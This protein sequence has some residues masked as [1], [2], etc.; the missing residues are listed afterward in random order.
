VAT[1]GCIWNR[2]LSNE[3]VRTLGFSFYRARH[4]LDTPYSLNMILGEKG[5]E[6]YYENLGRPSKNDKVYALGNVNEVPENDKYWFRFF[7]LRLANEKEIKRYE[8]IM[9]CREDGARKD[10]EDPLRQQRFTEITKRR[11][12]DGIKK[13]L[14]QLTN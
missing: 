4:I 11:Q 2:G 12:K 13:K 5:G 1:G 7:S 6:V 10:R 3:Y 8:F 9:R 14:V